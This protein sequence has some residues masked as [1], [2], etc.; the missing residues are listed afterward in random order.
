[1]EWDNLCINIQGQACSSIVCLWKNKKSIPD[2]E[3]TLKWPS[4]ERLFVNW[5]APVVDM[6]VEVDDK[7]VVVGDKWMW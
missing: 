6:E 1:M 5:D 2:N 3:K 7:K 4:F